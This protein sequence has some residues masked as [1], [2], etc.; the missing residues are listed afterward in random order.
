MLLAQLRDSFALEIHRA[1]Q[2]E[3]VGLLVLHLNVFP[4]RQECSINE[5]EVDPDLRQDCCARVSAQLCS[6]TNVPSRHSQSHSS[7]KREGVSD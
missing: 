4:V 1:L 5:L 2:P 6:V 3:V 7:N